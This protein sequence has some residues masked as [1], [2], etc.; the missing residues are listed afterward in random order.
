MAG[1]NLQQIFNANPASSLQPNDILYLIRAPYGAVNDMG[2][3][4]SALQ[5]S[6]G[7]LTWSVITTGTQTM[8]GNNGYIADNNSTRVVF[9]LPTSGAGI[10]TTIKVIGQGSQGWS[11]TQAAGQ[12]IIFGDLATT[13]GT[14]GSL[15]STNAHDCLELLCLVPNTTWIVVNSVGNVTIV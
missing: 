2:I 11:I 10:T 7:G 4:A 15:A 9:S 3:L 14:G 5:A 6:L 1:E 13:I 8:Q 12:Q